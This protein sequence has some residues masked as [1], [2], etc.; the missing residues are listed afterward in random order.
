MAH[1]YDI[2]EIKDICEYVLDHKLSDDEIYR[3]NKT[4]SY[5][6]DPRY[7]YGIISTKERLLRALSRGNYFI[8]NFSGGHGLCNKEVGGCYGYVDEE[9]YK[10]MIESEFIT[11]TGVILGKGY[12][13][14]ASSGGKRR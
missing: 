2:R 13:I 1:C 11:D 6:E 14:L 3:F 8:A 5:Y 12:E 10:N 7:G 9:L 4:I